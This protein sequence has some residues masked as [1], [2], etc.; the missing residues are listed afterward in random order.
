MRRTG[1]LETHSH[2]ELN[3]ARCSERKHPRPQTYPIRYA[4]SWGRPVHRPRRTRQQ[5]PNHIRRQIEVREVE[6]IVKADV[7]LDGPP[8]TE[9]V[10][11]TQFQIKC[12]K[13]ADPTLVRRRDRDRGSHST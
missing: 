13:S 4:I 9:P 12:P 2:P 5:P 10:R 8:L 1:T 6:Q 11:P 7:R 3:R